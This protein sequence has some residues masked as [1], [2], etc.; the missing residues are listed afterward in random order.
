MNVNAPC[1][2]ATAVTDCSVTAGSRGRRLQRV[3]RLGLGPLAGSHADALPF[4]EDREL[5]AEIFVP[6][7][8]RRGRGAPAFVRVM[9]CAVRSER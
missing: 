9:S 2:D 3:S 5:N 7:I 8:H 1:L 6:G 4:L